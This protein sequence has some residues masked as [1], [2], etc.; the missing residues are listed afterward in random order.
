[1]RMGLNRRRLQRFYSKRKSF[2]TIYLTAVLLIVAAVY[3]I[4][5]FFFRVQPIFV[6]HASSYVNNVATKAIN[7]SV[8]EVFSKEFI[9]YKDL[10]I[11]N[12]D[13]K[14]N[15]TSIEANISKINNLKSQIAGT[16]QSNLAKIDNGQI[17]IPIGSV[18]NNELMQGFGPKI[19]ITVVPTSV[20]NV[21]FDDEFVSSGINQ[22]RHK[23]FLVV[24]AKVSLVSRTMKK[25]ESVTNRVLVAE[26]IIV[27]STPEYYAENAPINTVID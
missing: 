27:G 9:S 11:I 24:T 18:F 22:V 26:T 17:L 3:F 7:D 5:T 8:N 19:P 15:V 2:I 10:V 1:M 12:T 16:T 21:D 4:V 23:I 14:G 6:S 25:S 13:E 20:V